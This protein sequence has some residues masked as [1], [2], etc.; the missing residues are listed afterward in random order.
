MQIE[1]DKDL[2]RLN[3]LGL[4]VKC[5]WYAQ[6]SSS[7]EVITLLKDKRFTS[8]PKL[9][10][11]SG[12]NILY[13]GDF[14]G[15]VIHPDIMEISI[16]GK[17]SDCIYIKAGAGIEWDNF[18]EWCVDRGWGGLEN[19][20]LIP[21]CVGASPVQNIGAYGSEVKDTI[22]SVEYVDIK[23]CEVNTLNTDD[24]KFGYRDSIFK[25]E[26][27]DRCVITFVTFKLAINPVPNIS[28]KDVSERLSQVRNP[29]IADVRK[30]IT[31]IRREKLPDPAV[32]GNAGSFF[33]NPVIPETDALKLREEYP[34]LKLF[35]ASESYSKV[36]AAWLIEQCGFKG[37]REGNVGV[38]PN[39]ALVL[40]AFE[41]ATGEE[42]LMLAQKIKRAVKTRF[43]ID[44]EME[45]NVT[46]SS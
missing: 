5:D 30:A 8:V 42:I 45:V 31:E 23:T 20:S 24:C 41:G 6:P 19:L 46:A 18:V 26:L 15:L 39:Q 16:S 4:R 7:D 17:E 36:P 37:I 22:V 11:G 25:H 33:K 34:S 21:G 1:R 38:H 28:Y 44:I 29:G 14:K 9:V 13:N 10:T 2:K 40:V 12:S 35:P 32:T 3:T 43:N 27:K